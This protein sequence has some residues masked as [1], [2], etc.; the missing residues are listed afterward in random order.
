MIVMDIH[1]TLRSRGDSL[2]VPFRCRFSSRVSAQWG[3]LRTER[4]PKRE[5]VIA[6]MRP[7]LRKT[8]GDALAGKAVFAKVCGQCE[9]LI[10][11]EL[12]PNVTWGVVDR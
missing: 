2:Y 4:D 7:F 8:S 12:I 9:Y 3:T 6:Q 11:F 10:K 1:F 5:E